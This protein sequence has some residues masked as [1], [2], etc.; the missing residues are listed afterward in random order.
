MLRH[1]IAPSRRYT[2][3]SHDVVRHPRLCS[4]AKILILYV[5]GLP[6]G[7][8]GLALSEHARKLGIRGR[9]FQRLKEQLLVHGY[10]HERRASGDRGQWA[11]HQLFSNVP[12]DDAG[13]RELW[14]REA[15]GLESGGGGCS[16]GGAPGGVRDDIPGGARPV[17]PRGSSRRSSAPSARFPTVGRPGPRAVGHQL[18]V[19]EERE[20]NSSRPPS[21][22][23]A[24]LVGTSDTAD[25]PGAREAA[26]AREADEARDAVE[27]AVT[28]DAADAA[29]TPE[30]VEFAEAERVLLSL[31]HSHR[32]LHLGVPEAR[33][34]VGQAV[35]WLR[36]GVSGADL[37]RVLTSDLPP[38]GVRSAVGFLRHRLVQKMPAP[39]TPAP[40]P[41]SGTAYVPRR[42]SGTTPAPPLPDAAPRYVPPLVTCEGP[43]TEHVFRSLGGETRCPDCE[44]EAA[45]ARWAECRIAALGGDALPG[46][47]EPRPDGWR[48]R[49]AAATEAAAARQAERET[50][51]TEGEAGD[52]ADGCGAGAA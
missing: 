31:R 49:L 47:G 17:S 11:T 42:E 40:A 20:K 41:A 18:P 22:A 35:E 33:A 14:R 8:A 21:E 32:E 25:G 30:A 29:E 6:E 19:D 36:R 26:S 7:E 50:G 10:V 5:Q 48:A 16:I 43:G 44:Q 9:A 1:A 52:R 34:L 27:S 39:V 38:G 15:E 2:K 45:W 46:P 12:L 4:D 51:E 3:A 28:A 13:A 37:R 23:V 24:V